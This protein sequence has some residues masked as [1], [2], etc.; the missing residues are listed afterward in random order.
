MSFVK[1]KYISFTGIKME[2]KQLNHNLRGPLQI[3]VSIS[4]KAC[5]S[6]VYAI[7]P[8]HLQVNVPNIQ[9]ST[10]SN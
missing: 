6:L 7:V 5:V 1:I 4:P 3:I 9:S 2:L 10:L 8:N